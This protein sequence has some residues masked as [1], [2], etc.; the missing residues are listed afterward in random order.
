MCLW[1]AVWR[2][3]ISCSHRSHNGPT[4]QQE[5][6]DKTK[7]APPTRICFVRTSAAELSNLTWKD[8]LIQRRACTHQLCGVGC[9]FIKCKCHNNSWCMC[10]R[11]EEE[12]GV[13]I[14]RPAVALFE[15]YMG[16]HLPAIFKWQTG[17]NE[18]RLALI[19][20]NQGQRQSSVKSPSSG[21]TEKQQ[22]MSFN[23]GNTEISMFTKQ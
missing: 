18:I 9:C 2:L 23:T 15:V 7:R 12:E 3:Y 11:W 8:E 5:L 22:R 20:G 6:M 19:G 14:V 10:R 16:I 17:Y 1:E 4:W 13:K 21:Q